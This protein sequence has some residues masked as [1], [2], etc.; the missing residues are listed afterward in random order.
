MV[1][2]END[3]L[4]SGGAGRPLGPPSRAGTPGSLGGNGR[5]PMMSPH[6]LGGNMVRIATL[7]SSDGIDLLGKESC[8]QCCKLLWCVVVA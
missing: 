1:Q 6:S 5:Q 7:A 2:Q 4:R 3:M 8:L